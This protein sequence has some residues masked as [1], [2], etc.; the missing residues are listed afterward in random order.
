M[1]G[2]AVPVVGP[3]QD[4][5][6]D[7]QQQRPDEHQRERRAAVREDEAPGLQPVRA[8]GGGEHGRGDRAQRDRDP[9]GGV[10]M[11][12]GAGPAGLLGLLVQQG[13]PGVGDDA[14]GHAGQQH[15]EQ[16]RRRVRHQAGREQ[17]GTGQGERQR[18]QAA[19]GEAGEHP[20]GGA[21]ADDRP[22]AQREDEQGE[23]DRPAVEVHRLQRGD[24]DAGRDRARDG[25]AGQHEHG[26]RART[27]LVDRALNGLG[28]AQALQR[29]A[30]ARRL[31][32]LGQVGQREAVEDQAGRR[33]E[34][35]GEVGAEGGLVQV[36]PVDPR[37]QQVADQR[38]GDEGGRPDGQGDERRAQGQAPHRVVV[39][40]QRPHGRVLGRR[41]GQQGRYGAVLGD[42][43]DAL[44]G[45][46]DEGGDQQTDEGFGAGPVDPGGRDG[47]QREPHPV[48]ADHR[49]AAVERTGRGEERGQRAQQDRAGEQGGQQSRADDGGDREGGTPVTAAEGPRRDGRLQRQQ[50]QDEEG[51]T[52]P[53]TPC[54]LGVP[55]S[56]Q[57]TEA[58]QGAYGTLAGV[59][60]QCSGCGGFHGWL[61]GS[62]HPASL[63]G[64]PG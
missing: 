33:E 44:G 57:R 2:H 34:R 21:D 45:A 61:L 58:Q 25:R 36:E 4:E 16:H 32:A 42:G 63:S 38:D 13:V 3:A 40:R 35:C 6:A 52:V 49:P 50:Q 22:A 10:Q 60:G 37:A 17:R 46:G 20:A 24:T 11:V 18:E 12:G 31:G 55:Q 29:G 51:D 9:D 39:V 53:D 28:A 8:D 27:A 64:V 1:E 47:E 56:P 41:R 14:G 7:G 43:P 26:D 30:H 5:R 62:R 59:H 19:P 54:E 15:Q 23:G 48:G